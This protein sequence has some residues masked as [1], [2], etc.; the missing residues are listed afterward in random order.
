MPRNVLLELSALPNT[1]VQHLTNQLMCVSTDIVKHTESSRPNKYIKTKYTVKCLNTRRCLRN[2]AIWALW[3]FWHT[4]VFF[5][6]SCNNKN[7]RVIQNQNPRDVYN[8]T[9]LIRHY[10]KTGYSATSQ[11]KQLFQHRVNS[12]NTR[13]KWNK[14]LAVSWLALIVDNTHIT[15]SSQICVHFF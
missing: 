3:M 4:L 5:K 8:S 9:S 11:V 2:E 14:I 1:A 15:H 12:Y 13:M 10:H 7:N 6:Q